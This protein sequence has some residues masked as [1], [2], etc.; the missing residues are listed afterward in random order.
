MTPLLIS[1]TLLDWGDTTSPEFTFGKKLESTL[2]GCIECT[3]FKSKLVILV[4]IIGLNTYH[5]L[6]D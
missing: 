2:E 1:I 6:K 4:K 5:L 3:R